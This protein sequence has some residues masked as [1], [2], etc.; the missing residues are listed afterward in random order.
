MV[1]SPHKMQNT[2]FATYDAFYSEHCSCITFGT[3]YLEF[4]NLLKSGLNL[5]HTV[6]KSKLWK[7]PPT[8]H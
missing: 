6:I 5:E 8:G 2:E 3:K 4:F 7:P 1:W